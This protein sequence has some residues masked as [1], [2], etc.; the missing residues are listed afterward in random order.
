MDS[1]SENEELSANFLGETHQYLVASEDTEGKSLEIFYRV[2]LRVLY[3]T[4]LCQV[5]D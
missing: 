5:A 3:N 1:A 2:F 4:S